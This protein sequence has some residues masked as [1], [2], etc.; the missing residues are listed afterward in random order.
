VQ[1]FKTK[2]K[3][4][5][6]IQALPYLQQHAA[7]SRPLAE[8]RKVAGGRADAARLGLGRHPIVENS[9]APSGFG[10]VA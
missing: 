2:K 8:V 7:L 6:V 3:K 10:A 5:G 9:L 1:Q 4:M